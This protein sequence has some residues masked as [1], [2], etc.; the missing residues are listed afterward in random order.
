MNSLTISLQSV[1][2]L[3]D[4]QFFQLC[5]NNSDLR[6]ERNFQGDITIMAPAGSETSA[7]NSDVN[8][9]L[10]FWN[11]RTKLGIVF[12][13]SGGF[14]LPNGSDRSP[15]A[16][17]IKKERWE[18]LTVEERSRFA[19][20]CPDFVMELM[21]P[22]DSLKTLQTKMQEYMDNGAGL[23]WLIN[24]RDREVEVYRLGQ[25]KEI[26]KSPQSLSGEDVLPD[27]V[28]DITTIW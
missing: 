18:A 20:I 16:S 13:S 2:E 6:F 22:S 3:T 4:E 28:L 25:P 11:R 15:D 21:S 9:D 27:F 1:I 8:A 10:V 7:R 23:G 14:K 5:H 24:R 26:L 12:D 19:P 17:W